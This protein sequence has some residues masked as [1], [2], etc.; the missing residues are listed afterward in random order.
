MTCPP[1]ILC[2][3]PGA[4]YSIPPLTIRHKRV[5]VMR[6]ISAILFFKSK[7]KR[8]DFWNQGKFFL[9]QFKSSFR[10]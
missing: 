7:R 1:P 3:P 8:E 2:P 9:F 6:D 5:K 4:Y 10:S